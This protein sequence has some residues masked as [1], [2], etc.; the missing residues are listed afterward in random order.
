VELK[1]KCSQPGAPGASCDLPK[2][3]EKDLCEIPDDVRCEMEFVFVEQIKDVLTAIIPE[4][5]RGWNVA[6]AP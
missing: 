1:R 5:G 6:T 4:L 3:N 2:E